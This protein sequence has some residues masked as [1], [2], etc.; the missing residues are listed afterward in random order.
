[1]TSA[2]PIT[3]DNGATTP[4]DPANFYD[5][6]KNAYLL[7]KIGSDANSHG[8]LEHFTKISL[9]LLNPP[10]FLSDKGTYTPTSPVFPNPTSKVLPFPAIPLADYRFPNRQ[11]RVL[12]E[13]GPPAEILR[14]SHQLS[15]RKWQAGQ[16]FRQAAPGLE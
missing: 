12:V 15:P 10:D 2:N 6:D 1:M 9:F 8:T 4:N 13:D 14:P 11:I 16:G 3:T 5:P 7:L